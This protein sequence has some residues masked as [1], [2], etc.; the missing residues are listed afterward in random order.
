[1]FT[2]RC[3]LMDRT[4]DSGECDG[5]TWEDFAPLV[6][7]LIGGDQHEA[8]LVSTYQRRLGC[9]LRSGALRMSLFL[10][11]ENQ[12]ALAHGVPRVDDRRV[13]SGIV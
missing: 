9:D 3:G 4:V 7:G 6:A 10:L 8:A 1:M 12:M 2:E 5:G 11:S 13:V